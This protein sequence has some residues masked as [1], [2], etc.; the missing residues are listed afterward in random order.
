MVE[1][2]IL[3]RFYLHDGSITQNGA[4]V[5]LVSTSDNNAGAIKINSSSDYSYVS[6]DFMLIDIIMET[7][8]V[9][10]W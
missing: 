3:K 2:L 4:N 5:T 9:G 10:E 1:L 8:M 7:Q 6:G